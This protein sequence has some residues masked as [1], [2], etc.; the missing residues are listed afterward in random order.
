MALGYNSGYQESISVHPTRRQIFAGKPYS[1]FPNIW[2][3][4]MLTNH[5]SQFHQPPKYR[6]CRQIL[7]SFPPVSRAWP[8]GRWWRW[9]KWNGAAEL[10]PAALIHLHSQILPWVSGE[11]YLR[12]LTFIP[13]FYS[14]VNL[15]VPKNWA[16]YF[17]AIS[18]QKIDLTTVL[19]SCWPI[20]WRKRGFIAS[21]P[22]SSFFL[23]FAHEKN[24][25]PVVKIGFRGHTSH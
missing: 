14:W 20:E 8:G 7:K 15:V 3:W 25:F 11:I 12:V 2:E 18:G 1:T 16:A 5:W 17:S 21:G 9:G 10:P 24:H 22:F 13:N 19:R 4:L 6:Q 23:T